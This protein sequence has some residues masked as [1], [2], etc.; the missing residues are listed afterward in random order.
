MLRCTKDK[1]HN[2]FLYKAIQEFT[3]FVDGDGEFVGPG[4]VDT[5]A[6]GYFCNICGSPLFDDEVSE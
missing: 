4:N 6:E 3:E 5:K 2:I 1:T